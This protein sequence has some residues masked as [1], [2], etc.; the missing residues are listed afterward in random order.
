MLPYFIPY[1]LSFL[2]SSLPVFYRK[3]EKLIFPIVFFVL[4][5][6]AASRGIYVDRDSPT[7]VDIFQ[8]LLGSQVEYLTFN[9]I[10]IYEPSFYIIPLISHFLVGES[11]YLYLTFSIFAFLGVYFKLKSFYL[12][13]SFFLSVI[14]YVSSLY[15]LHEMTQIRIGVATGILLLSL[16]Y[17]YN[18][19]FFPFILLI[20]FACF[21][22]YSSILFF[23]VYF[24]DRYKIHKNLSLFAIIGAYILATFKVN[25]LQVSGIGFL[26]PKVELYMMRAEKGIDEEL[27]I[28]NFNVLLSLIFTIVFL[29]KSH[30]FIPKNKYFILM[31][32]INIISILSFLIFLPVPVL[33]ARVSQIFNIVQICLYPSIIYLFDKKAIGYSLIISLSLMKIYKCF[34]GD[35]IFFP[36]YTW[37]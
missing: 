27:S 25:I 10:A 16:R 33:A 5:V 34:Y 26:F 19:K 2:L 31:L 36:F 6:F 35:K 1:I 17:V 13:N 22:H 7:Y 4:F 9:R 32:K 37:W 30:Q 18:R 12:S 11:Y 15:F 3:I 23:P 28:W 14:F 24:L 21:F 20:I 29:L 8:K